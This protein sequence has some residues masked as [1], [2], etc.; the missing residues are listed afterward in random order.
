LST[1]QR[2]RPGPPVAT[3]VSTGVAGDGCSV[4]VRAFPWATLPRASARASKTLAVLRRLLEGPS[5]ASRAVAA[6]SEL[7]GASVEVMAHAAGPAGASGSATLA[8]NVLSIQLSAPPNAAGISPWWLVIEVEPPLV[9]ALVAKALR[10]PAPRV[11][12]ADVVTPRL[13]GA[14]AAIL[15][16]AIRRAGV[17]AVVTYAG[18][19]SVPETARDEVT[20]ASVTVSTLEQATHARLFFPTAL[21]AASPPPLDA[22]AVASLGDVPLELPV[23]ACRVLTTPVELASLAV[24]DAWMLGDSWTLGPLSSGPR[25][26]VW[27]CAG[28]AERAVPAHLEASGQIVLREGL[29]ELGWSPMNDEADVSTAVSEAVGEAPVVVRVEV[30]AARM[31][32][33]EWGSLRPG[34]VVGLG[35]KVG[36]TVTLRVSGLAIAEGELVDLDGEVGVRIRRR[37]SAGAA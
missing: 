11:L 16:A 25:G 21:L 29:E 19:A 9:V 27:L 6:T 30:G 2:D 20:V 24:G 14:F 3:L 15:A 22:S 8:V 26:P 28:D 10:R 4:S 23:I 34:D 12:H 7:V 33:R 17:P 37:L 36:G 31:T 1:A 18:L 32:A 35:A 13:A 5:V